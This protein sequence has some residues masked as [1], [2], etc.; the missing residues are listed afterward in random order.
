[1]TT[2]R[3]WLCF[4]SLTVAGLLSAFLSF[5]GA[6]GLSW[7]GFPRDGHS[8]FL[9]PLFIP[10]LVAFPLFLFALGVSKLASLAL[11]ICVPSSW[12]AVFETSVQDF[13]GG[14]LDF[15]KFLAECCYMA[16]PLL[17]LAALVQFGTQFYEFTYDRQWV[18][19]KEANHEPAD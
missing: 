13:K 2:S 1:M 5:L 19:W 7:G 17:L 18:R 4:G 8:A 12:L 16:L 15:V 11:W 10:F 14:P 3:K 6:F 9:L